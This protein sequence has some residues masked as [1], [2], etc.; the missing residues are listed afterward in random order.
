MNI[1]FTQKEINFMK[2]VLNVPDPTFIVEKVCKQ[3]FEQLV[4]Q[5]VQAKSTDEKLDIIIKK[6]KSVV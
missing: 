4:N 5:Q 3:W 2:Q 6:E 1:N